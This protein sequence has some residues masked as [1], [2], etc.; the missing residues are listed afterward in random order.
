M[1]QCMICGNIVSDDAHFCDACGAECN[2]Q[3]VYENQQAYSS[4]EE[5]NMPQGDISEQYT[6]Q[7]E[8]NNYMNLKPED[9]AENN[10]RKSKK[11][12]IVSLLICVFVLAFGTGVIYFAVFKETPQKKALDRYFEALDDM[13][14]DKIMEASYPPDICEKR[15]NILN[16]DNA[17]DINV[18]SDNSGLGL[19]RGAYDDVECRNLVGVV[20][21]SYKIN[22]VTKEGINEYRLVKQNRD[23][24]DTLSVSYDLIDIKPFDK[25]NFEAYIGGKEQEWEKVGIDSI[26]RMVNYTNISDG[27]VTSVDIEDVYI[28]QVH[29][30]WK[31]G[32]YMY[33]FDKSWWDD[34]EFVKYGNNKYKT[35]S[36]IIQDYKDRVYPIIVYKVDGEWYALGGPYLS[37]LAKNYRVGE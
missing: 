3:Q 17:A 12:K 11:R 21:D 28:A 34:E 29:I 1:R 31:Y 4:E 37:V 32:N 35:Y 2:Y 24:Y 6:S 9:V 23:F 36:E 27:T 18:C 22:G 13:D 16:S 10:Y 20:K 14:F 7:N 19:T 30:T 8:I 25:V 5:Y 26:E 15:L 33:G